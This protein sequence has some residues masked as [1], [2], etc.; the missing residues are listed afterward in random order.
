MAGGQGGQLP[1]QVWQNRSRRR[2]AAARCI[3][4]W[5][6]IFEYLAIDAPAWYFNHY[7]KPG[8]GGGEL[9]E[10][11]TFKGS[12]PASESKEKPTVAVWKVSQN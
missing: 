9:A 2:A 4:T 3:T 11:E 6:P 10:S 7:R 8:H 12:S 1:A 5:P